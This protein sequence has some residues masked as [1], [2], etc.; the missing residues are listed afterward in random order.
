MTRDELVATAKDVATQL[1]L[2]PV[3]VCAIVERE[4]TWDPNSERYEPGFYEEYIV[5]QKLKSPT[6]AITRAISRGLMQIMGESARERGFTGQL[7]TLFVPYVGL[8][9]G[10]KH[11]QLK[12]EHAKGDLHIALER[13]NGGSNIHYADEVFAM[14]EHY[15]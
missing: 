5:P 15:K 10:C 7:S 6:E 12:I 8:W 4:S 13:W 14:M 9:W 2:D 3:L 1:A 11:L